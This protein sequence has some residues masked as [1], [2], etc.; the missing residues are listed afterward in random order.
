MRHPLAR[1]GRPVIS[2]AINIA[3]EDGTRGPFTTEAEVTEA[4]IRYRDRNP[5]D[6]DFLGRDGVGDAA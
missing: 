3:N 2:Y 6:T 1:Y 5:D 4:L